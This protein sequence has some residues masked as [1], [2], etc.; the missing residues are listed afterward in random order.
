MIKVDYYNPL[1]EDIIPLNLLFDISLR[2]IYKR[3]YKQINN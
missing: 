1:I 2:L 3:F